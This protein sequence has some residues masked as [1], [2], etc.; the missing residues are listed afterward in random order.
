[1]KAKVPISLFT[2]GNADMMSAVGV[3]PRVPQ[4]DVVAQISKN[5]SECLVR[6]AENPIS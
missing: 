3:A 2:V 1:M 6:S 5:K 4:P